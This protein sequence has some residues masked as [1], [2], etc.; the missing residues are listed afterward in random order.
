MIR[1][2]IAEDS[3]THRDLLIHIL[4][5]DPEIR[6]VGLVANGEEAVAAVHRLNPTV[7]M[8]DVHMP[9]MNGFEATRR[10][11]S[12]RPVPIVTVSGTLENPAA[13]F[14]SLEAGALAFVQQPPGPDHP[15]HQAHAAQLLSTV[16]LMAEVRLVRRW[17]ERRP[18]TQPNSGQPPAIGVAPVEIKV[19]AA[20]ASTGG[21]VVLQG[22]LSAVARHLNVPVLIVQHITAGFAQGFAEW[23]GATCGLPAQIAVE[24]ERTL[25]GRVYVAPEGAHMGITSSGRISLDHG[26]P[27]HGL[28]PS[29]SHLFRST[30]EAM[31]P[32]AIGILLTGMG[33][34]GAQELKLMKDKGAITIVQDEE[35][36]IVH[37]MA[38]EAMRLDAARYVLSP[39]EIVAALS[40]LLRSDAEA[41]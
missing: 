27:E 7:V 10:I 41:R 5:S 19:I 14:Q 24:G 37:G 12:T 30:A 4:E 11:M 2:V 33:T 32:S 23:I 21:P 40:V 18:A 28:R 3:P 22:I 20:G 17:T 13:S 8:M 25:P 36:S 38:G 6:V 15:D 26:P 31:G 35:S 39:R 34:D 1:V 29:I 9:R 16:K